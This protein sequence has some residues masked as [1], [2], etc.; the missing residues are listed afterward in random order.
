[1]NSHQAAT[2]CYEFEEVF[3]AFW[4]RETRANVVVEK[5]GI[6]LRE[7]LLIKHC[8]VFTD[9]C[10]KRSS[11]FAKLAK[12]FTACENGCTVTIVFDVAIEDE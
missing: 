7:F 3:P 9:D 8:R 2:A 1:M 10:L 5:D 11:S 6:E 12:G 4:F